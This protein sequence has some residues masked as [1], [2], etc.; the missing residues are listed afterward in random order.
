VLGVLA[1]AG[2]VQAAGRGAGQS[3]GV[4][5][6]AVGKEPGVTGNGRAVELQLDLTVEVNALGVILTVTH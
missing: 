1:G 6:F 4:V 2:V 3:E 5:E